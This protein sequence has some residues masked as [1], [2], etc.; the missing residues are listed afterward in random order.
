M[1]AHQR[2]FFLGLMHEGLIKIVLANLNDDFISYAGANLIAAFGEETSRPYSLQR[3]MS[4]L[5]RFRLIGFKNWSH[6]ECFVVHHLVASLVVSRL[7]C[8]ILL[9]WLVRLSVTFRSLRGS[10]QRHHGDIDERSN[11]SPWSRKT[12]GWGQSRM[13]METWRQQGS[14]LCLRWRTLSVKAFVLCKYLS[15]VLHR[16]PFNEQLRCLT[17]EFQSRVI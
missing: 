6:H 8:R 16:M 15:V 4:S 9:C 7:A 5:F 2:T 12:H 13:V 1:S 3:N 14:Y 11:A 17:V 10:Y